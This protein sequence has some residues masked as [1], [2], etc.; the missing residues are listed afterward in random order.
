MTSGGGDE[1]LNQP[2]LINWHSLC[3]LQHAAGEE[4]NGSLVSLYWG[5]CVSYEVWGAISPVR[6]VCLWGWCNKAWC[7]DYGRIHTGVFHTVFWVGNV[8]FYK[9]LSDNMKWKENDKWNILF[10]IVWPFPI[11]GQPS[12]WHTF[13]HIHTS[14]NPFVYVHTTLAEWLTLKFISPG[15]RRTHDLQVIPRDRD[16]SLQAIRANHYT[17]DNYMGKWGSVYF[18]NC[19]HI[20]IV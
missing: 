6:H 11:E 7:S 4:V 9:G 18:I 10:I 3:V 8:L 16:T 14:Y 20:L 19:N 12:L 17:N 13:I 5:Q 2:L 15:G 1:K